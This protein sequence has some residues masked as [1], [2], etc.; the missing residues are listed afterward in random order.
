MSTWMLKRNP[1]LDDMSD[2][3]L[4]EYIDRQAER[5][6]DAAIAAAQGEETLYHRKLAAMSPIEQL[7]E[8][9]SPYSDRMKQKLDELRETRQ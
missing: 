1:N 6:M 4:R 8:L 9:M 7:R 3:D 2:Q 5:A